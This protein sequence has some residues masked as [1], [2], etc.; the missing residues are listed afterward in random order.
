MK[1]ITI[2]ISMLTV[3][4]FNVNGQST[5]VKGL[6]DKQET[7]TEI[8]KTIASN[9]QLMM[10]F[11]KVA[12][13]YDHS[14][15]M[16]SNAENH[17]RIEMEAK[18]ASMA[19]M[20]DEHQMMGMMKDNPE[21]MQK[22]MGKMMQMC[23]KDTAMRNQMVNMMTEH[24]EMMNMCTQKMKEKGR[25]NPGGKMMNPKEKSHHENYKH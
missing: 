25:M 15:M 18:K 8:F 14:A 13:E 16:M 7:R 24:P 22:M 4:V 9:H 10:E 20:N 21:M 3:L 2:L 17:Q 6:L 23:E 12:K 19:D 5:A 11:M 1:T